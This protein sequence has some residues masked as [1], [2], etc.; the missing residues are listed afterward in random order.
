MLIAATHRAMAR[1]ALV[2][3]KQ[4]SE[5]QIP[6]LPG[7]VEFVGGDGRAYLDSLDGWVHVY[8]PTLEYGEQIQLDGFFSKLFRPITRVFKKI[9]AIPKKVFQQIKRNASKLNEQRKKVFRSI[10]KNK[11]TRQVLRVAGVAL[12]PFTA[13]LSLAVAE[14]AARYGKARYVQGQSRSSAWKRGAVGAVVGYAGG[15]AISAGYSAIQKG[16]LTALNP[17]SGSGATAGA[18]SSTSAAATTAAG[19]GTAS[20]GGLWSTIGNTALT[21]AKKVGTTF[22]TSY[23]TQMASGR[24][25]SAEHVAYDALA[26]TYLPD[27]AMPIYDS[28]ANAGYGQGIPSTA[29]GAEMPFGTEVPDGEYFVDQEGEQ[30][31]QG[32]ARWLPVIAVAGVIGVGGYLVLKK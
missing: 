24:K 9:T 1:P 22:A 19:T 32:F 10:T 13:G 16:G 27:S 14:G 3:P 29:T 23:L 11:Y 5:D 31:A 25:P 28:W 7:I 6:Y 18:T 20:T 26:Q 2:V 15:R 12:S 17:F 30:R 4:F 21:A 8:E